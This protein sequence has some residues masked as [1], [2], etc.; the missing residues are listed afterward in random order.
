[1]GVIAWRVNLKRDITS[2]EPDMQAVRNFIDL[3]LSSP[4]TNPPVVMLVSS[5]LVFWSEWLFKR[6]VAVFWLA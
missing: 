6:I 4:C 2:F 1:M 5:I 3:A